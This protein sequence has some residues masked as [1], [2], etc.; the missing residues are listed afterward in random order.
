MARVRKNPNDALK[1][2]IPWKVALYIRLSREDGN[3]ESY[4]VINQRQRLKEFLETS[5]QSDEMELVDI[6]V[7]DGYTGTDS[8]REQ[9]QRLLNDIDKGVVNCVIVK[10]AYVKLRIKKYCVCVKT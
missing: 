2:I 4:S 8:D 6:Y 7:D 1:P 9:F 5:M 3:D 10:D